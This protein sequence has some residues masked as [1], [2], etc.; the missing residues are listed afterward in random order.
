MEGPLKILHLEDNSLDAELKHDCIRRDGIN[1][2]MELVPKKSDLL[3]A[4][5]KQGSV[6]SVFLNAD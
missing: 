2:E 6:F 3:S 1:C 4:I 5:E